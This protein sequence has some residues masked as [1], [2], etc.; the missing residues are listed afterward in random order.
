MY[1][2]SLA[3]KI[4]LC[5]PCDMSSIIIALFHVDVPC[6]YAKLYIALRNYVTTIIY[7]SSCDFCEYKQSIN[8]S[9]NVAIYSFG[10]LNPFHR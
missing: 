5:N 10:A 9:V 6:L 2:F 8:I 4:E 7:T 3:H 1:D